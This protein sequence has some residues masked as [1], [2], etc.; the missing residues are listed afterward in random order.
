MSAWKYGIEIVIQDKQLLPPT[1]QAYG[2]LL[3]GVLGA[4]EHVVIAAGYSGFS[5]AVKVRE[6]HMGQVFHPVSQNWSRQDLP[7]P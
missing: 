4:G 7:A 3:L 1:S 5:G 2:D 6:A